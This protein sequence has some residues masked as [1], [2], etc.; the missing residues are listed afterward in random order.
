M[1]NIIYNF[2]LIFETDKIQLELHFWDM[3]QLEPKILTVKISQ[4]S[5]VRI[6]AESQRASVTKTLTFKMSQNSTVN[7]TQNSRVKIQARNPGL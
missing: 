2:N 1:L 5:R 6:L 3:I 4:N 7:K